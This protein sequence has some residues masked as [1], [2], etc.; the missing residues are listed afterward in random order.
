MR[1]RA[2]DRA[3][4]QQAWGPQFKPLYYPPKKVSVGKSHEVENITFSCLQLNIHRI[5]SVIRVRSYW[6][7]SQSSLELVILWLFS[8]LVIQMLSLTWCPYPWSAS[9]RREGHSQGK[10]RTNQVLVTHAYNP[11]YLG[12][13]DLEDQSSRPAQKNSSKD[14]YL[15]K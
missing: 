9:E 7:C 5:S 15:Q 3:P 13:W 2:G 8:L 1:K 14:P 4:A 10:S 6:T 12:S 11:S